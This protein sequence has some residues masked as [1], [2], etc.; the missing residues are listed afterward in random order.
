MAI[1]RQTYFSLA[2]FVLFGI[3]FVQTLTAQNCPKIEIAQSDGVLFP[4]RS[5]MVSV[6]DSSKSPELAYEWSVSLG[7]IVNGQK[8][9]TVEIVAGREPG[10]ITVRVVV[11]G[12][13]SQ[14]PS[15]FTKTI[16]VLPICVL[17]VAA[18]KFG[19]VG[20]LEARAIIDNIFVQLSINQTNR[21]FF[22][23]S[24]KPT[25]S[26]SARRLRIRQI[27]DA[28]A[29]RKYDLSRIDFEI[30]EEDNLSTRI[31]IVPPSAASSYAEAGVPWIAGAEMIRRLTTLFANKK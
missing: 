14:C 6:V 3:A 2:A 1:R 21:A 16:D 19:L 22:R 28:I 30:I 13:P 10:E 23:M 25:E 15:S 31:Y 7:A 20:K 8:T 5:T 27:L 29:F 26:L 18:D 11:S 12:L 17:P 24:F 9:C 4:G